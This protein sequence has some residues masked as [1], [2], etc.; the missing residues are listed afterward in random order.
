HRDVELMRAMRMAQKPKPIDQ[1]AHKKL[2]DRV[3]PQGQGAS[4]SAPR[5][6][7]GPRAVW[8]PIGLA[9]SAA[10][11][12][13]LLAIHVRPSSAPPQA[14]LLRT[15]TTS[16]LSEAPF[17]KEGDTSK[18]VDAIALARGRDLRANKWSKWGVK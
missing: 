15:R 18:R 7:L 10:A 17:P 3:V 5:H 4:P 16:D 1:I 11:P 12:V 6:P 14:T 2:L 9:L 8:Y 13:A